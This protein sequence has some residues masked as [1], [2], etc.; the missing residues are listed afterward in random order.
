MAGEFITEKFSFDNP[1]EDILALFASGWVVSRVLLVSDVAEAAAIIIRSP[2][3]RKGQPPV[4]PDL[5][6]L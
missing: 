5:K 2:W 6:R 3:T 4:W 1:E